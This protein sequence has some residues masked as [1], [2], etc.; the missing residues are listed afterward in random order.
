MTINSG[1]LKLLVLFTW[2]LAFS[3]SGNAQPGC[4]NIVTG[5]NLSVDCNVNCVDLTAEVLETGETSTYTVSSIPYAPPAPYTGGVAQFINQDDTWGSVIALPFNFCFYENVYSSVVVGANGLITFDVALAT[6]YCAWSFSASCPTPGP[7]PAGLYNNSVMGAFHDIDPRKGGDI[8]YFIQGTAPCRMFIVSFNNVPHYDCDC[9]FFSSCKRTTQQIVL[10]ETTNVIEV[11]LQKKETCSGWNS[12]N[13]VIGIQDATGANGISPP[14]RNTGPWSATNEGWRFTPDG[15]PNFVVTWY[16]GNATAIGTGL[17][18][19]VC[20]S[21]TT[22]Y[23]AE[24]VYTNCDQA[25]VTV[26]DQVTVTQNSTVSVSVTP[27]SAA[28]CGPQTVDLIASS[29]SPGVSYSWSPAAGLSTTTG[30]TTTA[31]P[32]VTTLYTVT[33]DDGNCSASANVNVTVVDIQTTTASTD[34][35]CAGDDGTATVTPTGGLA[36]YSYSWNTVPVQSTQTA[37]GLGGGSYTVTITDAT[38]CTATATVT[39]GTTLGSLSPPTMSSTD[40]ICSTPNG[41][42]TATAV[43]GNPPFTYIWDTNPVQTTQT[44]TGLASGTYNVTITDAGGCQSSA[45][46]VVETDPGNFAVNI[47]TFSNLSCNGVCNGTATVTMANGTA[48]Y[49]T[50]WDDALFQQAPQATDLCAGTYN[51]G[52]IDANGCMAT[53]QVVITEPT[54]IVAT[55]VM[56]IPSNCGSPNGQV[57]ATATGGTVASAYSYSWNTAPVQTTATA[58]GLIPATYTVTVTDDNGCTASTDVQVTSTPSFTATISA[59]SNTSCFQLCDGEATVAASGSATP[60]LSYAWNTTPVQT[61]ATATGLCAGMYEVAV[62]DAVGCMATTSVTI[63]EPSMVSTSVTASASPICIGESSVLTGTIYGGTPPYSSTVWTASPTDPSLISTQQNPTVSPLITTGYSLIATDANGCISVPKAVTIVVLDPLTL[64]VTRPY[65]SPDTGICP[66][67][68]AIID[69][70]A[71]GG[72]GVYSY[73]LQPDLTTPISL[74]MQV[75]P[76]TTTTYDFVVTDGCTT[77][78]ATAS[79]TITIFVIPT[80]DFMGDK[81]EGC[82]PH[83][84]NFTDQTIPT[85]VFWDWI[86]GDPNSGNN[87]ASVTNPS[88]VYSTPGLYEVSLAVRSANGCISDSTK[89]AYIEVFPLPKAKFAAN[90]KRTT[91]IDAEIHFTDLST[92][93]IVAWNWDLGAGTNSTEQ[94]PVYTYPDTGTY[95]VWLQVTNN[96]GC[97]DEIS[98]QIEIEPEFMFYIPSAFSPNADNRNEFFRA[99]GEGVDWSTYQMT[100]FNRWGQEIFHTNNV[101][102]PWDGSYKGKQV[103]NDTYVWTVT[104]FDLK[105]NAHVYRG[106]V[107]VVR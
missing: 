8:S 45:S 47:A 56:D 72:D 68:F 97:Q 50:A 13:A 104:V 10:Y 89:T 24:V 66:Y 5:P 44:A 15:A 38:G 54:A 76:T 95:L 33:V 52:V 87:T 20:P 106:H 40:A 19:N 27:T 3:F 73:F 11:Y 14:G 101:E 42:A 98:Q 6:Q 23:T 92:D 51:V 82:E 18:L 84:V 90:P 100:V 22:T 88:H 67:D 71:S 41:T 30:P 70:A 4:P 58:T 21:A 25:V 81:L 7:P 94:H 46:V 105:G 35:S 43:D 49:Q 28:L 63:T 60:P 78:Q 55:A 57:S 77:P 102:N 86:F 1:F 75:Q 93:S 29:P 53:A 96:Y 91:V 80:V 103:P 2:V 59:F 34:A 61:S 16:D 32:S 85:P 9:G 26:T 74:P 69:L 36:P 107:T 12:G 62:A 48:P 17:T 99:Y 64:W 83:R 79:S 39:V 65:A 37:T 31:S